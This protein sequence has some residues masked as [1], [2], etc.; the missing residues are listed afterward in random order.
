MQTKPLMLLLLL[1]LLGAVIHPGWAQSSPAGDTATAITPVSWLPRQLDVGKIPFGRP[2]TRNF[3]VEN[4]S[5][6]MLLITH[7]RTGCH[8]TTASWTPEAIAPGS[9]GMVHITFD[10]LREDEFYKV[11]IVS[12]N[13]DNQPPVGLIFKGIVDK[14]STQTGP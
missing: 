8:C 5:D 3:I 1:L 4:N 14:K 6:S 12:T 7:V 13:Q 11:I 9:R 10:A 2:V